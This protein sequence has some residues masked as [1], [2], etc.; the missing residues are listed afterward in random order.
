MEIKIPR[1]FY[2]DHC[3]RDLEAPDVIRSTKQHYYIDGTSPHLAELLSDAEY[4]EDPQGFDRH[5]FGLCM[6]AKATA[7]AIRAAL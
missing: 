1:S 2:D 5:V 3:E 6:S 7:K 4:Y